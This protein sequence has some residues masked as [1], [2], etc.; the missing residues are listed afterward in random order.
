MKIG[1]HWKT[2]QKL[3]QD[4]YDSSTHYAVATVKEDGT[5]HITPIGSLILRDDHTG[6]YFEEFPDGLP[7]NLKKNQR[8]CV[9][10]INSS[11][12]F[13]LKSFI[14]GKFPTPP[15]VRLWGNAGKKRLATPDELKEWHKRIEKAKPLKG[16]DL[17]WKDMKYVRDITFN[18]F[19]PVNCGEMTARTW[20]V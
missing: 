10:A 11:K 8:V 5:P 1:E 13:W 12:S 9:L 20:A 3:F 4:A 2:I 18:S 14:R 16:Y 6:Y 15:G 7:K 17:L 19:E